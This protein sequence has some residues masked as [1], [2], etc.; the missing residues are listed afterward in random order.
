MELALNAQVN[1]TDCP[2]GQVT[3]L[4]INPV[5]QKITHIVATEKGDKG[6]EYLIPADLIT[7]CNEKEV[8]LSLTEIEFFLQKPFIEYELVPLEEDDSVGTSGIVAWPYATSPD[9]RA[10]YEPVE[11]IPHGELAVK[12]GYE[13][14]ATDGRVGTV[15]GF[16]INPDSDAITH[17]VVHEKHLSWKEVLHSK[18]YDAVPVSEIDRVDADNNT[19]YLK[20]DKKAVKGLTAVSAS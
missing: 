1:C 19:V 9:H 2:M 11:Q 6:E 12:R 14:K 4:I 10:G 20:L 16:I 3:R 18:K 15:S 8:Q 17:L 13:V 5:S 7:D